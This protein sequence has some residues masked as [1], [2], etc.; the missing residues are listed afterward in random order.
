MGFIVS[1]ILPKSPAGSP[2]LQLFV[3]TFISKTPDLMINKLL[4]P[5]LSPKSRLASATSTDSSATRTHPPPLP[6]RSISAI[7]LRM[8]HANSSWSGKSASF[9]NNQPT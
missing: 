3:A 2:D 8:Q 5:R 1:S 4:H 6:S 7:C 9:G